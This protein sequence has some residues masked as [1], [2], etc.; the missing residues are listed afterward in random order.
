ME[1][2]A[3]APHFRSLGVGKMKVE[4]A[5]SVLV[6]AGRPEAGLSD[7]DLAHRMIWDD[8]FSVD[9]AALYLSELIDKYGM[10]EKG[11]YLAYAL[12]DPAQEA[13][14]SRPESLLANNATLRARSVRYDAYFSMWLQSPPLPSPTPNPPPVAPAPGP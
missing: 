2:Q 14:R 4:R 6:N 3:G 7:E 12:S 11:A 13:L 5:R 10:T 8:R 9:L 1:S